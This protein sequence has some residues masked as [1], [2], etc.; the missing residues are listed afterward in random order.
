MGGHYETDDRYLP[1]CGSDAA[2]RRLGAGKPHLMQEG[3]VRQRRRRRSRE[4]AAV[5]QTERTA[6][7]MQIQ[8]T[9]RYLLRMD[10][11]GI[12]KVYEADGITL[13]FETNI[14]AE[15]LSVQTREQLSNGIPVDDERELYDLLESY[16]S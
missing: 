4:D 15:R 16:S 5:A 2:C 13:L 1:F 7:S 3:S 8:K 6:E 14:R 12:L 9:C 10:D 11:D